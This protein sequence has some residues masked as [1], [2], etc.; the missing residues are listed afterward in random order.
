M[1]VAHTLG[2]EEVVRVVPIKPVSSFRVLSSSRIFKA[3]GNV[4]VICR[5]KALGTG[6]LVW[7]SL[8]LLSSHF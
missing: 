1:F 4:T 7:G 2:T 8:H 3:K 6:D 5:L